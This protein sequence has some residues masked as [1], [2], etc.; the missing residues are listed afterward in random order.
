VKVG[1]FSPLPPSRSG[2]ADYA[3]AL[4]AD[5]KRHGQVEAG[6]KRCDI[7][8]Y[9]LGNNALHAGTYRQA[10]ER[11]GVVV[12]HDAVLHHFF[13]GQLSEAAYLNEFAY[14]YGEW[15]RGLARDLWHGRAASG[16]DERYFR[17]PMLKRIGE[18]SLAVVVHNPA[19]ARA[20]SEHAPEA[21]VREIPHL[22]FSPANR[23]SGVDVIR[24]RETLGVPAG[25][26]VFAVFGYLRE[27]KRL[28][29]VL[30]AFA[31]LHRQYPQTALLVAG[32][33]VSTDLAR[34][35]EPMRSAPG[36]LRLPFL[37]ERDFQLAAGA[38]DVCI[39]L[40]HPSAG[41]SS[42][43]AVRLMELGK[44][45]LVTESEEYARVPDGACIRIPAGPSERDSLLQHMVMLTAFGGVAGA[46]GERAAAHIQQSHRLE[47]VSERYWDVLREARAMILSEHQG[48]LSTHG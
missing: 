23:P 33:F 36:V 44:P 13:L 30:E 9:H 24:Y 21:R 40:R 27:S 3:A 16:S 19:A 8:L 47:L 43:I 39:N 46:V 15:S 20:V 31:N 32:E 4:L 18:R 29:S 1:F 37:E 5:L 35:V 38:A 14:N 34:A 10:M 7:A 12:L 25:T 42:G 11:P 22:A 28:I 48:G 2:V 6:A 41:E 45:V 26:L 17:Y